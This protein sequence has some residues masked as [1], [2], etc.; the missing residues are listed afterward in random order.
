MEWPG[1]DAMGFSCKDPRPV[2]KSMDSAPR[3]SPFRSRLAG[4]PSPSPP[5]Q[6]SQLD[7]K[8][9][10]SPTGPIPG[11]GKMPPCH[12]VTWIRSI[13]IPAS[14]CPGCSRTNPLQSLL[15]GVQQEHLYPNS[16]AW[17]AAG[18]SHLR[19]PFPGDVM[20]HESSG[21]YIPN[22]TAPQKSAPGHCSASTG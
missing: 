16:P 10:R 2:P 6:M 14:H 20:G 4:D 17:G 18:H 5:C 19:P 13:L 7:S 12:P 1:G 22:P 9:P 15:L 21:T 3:G 11:R 8:K